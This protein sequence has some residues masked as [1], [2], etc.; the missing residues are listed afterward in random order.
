[1][2]RRDSMRSR[3]SSDRCWSSNSRRR[4][5]NCNNSSDRCWNNNSDKRLSSNGGK[6]SSSSDKRW[7][8]SS[9][10]CN[11]NNNSNALPLLRQ[12]WL[13]RGERE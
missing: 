3:N 6:S 9:R 4:W 12:R 10:C 1:M 5:H 2:R 7:S 13:R 11:C 8:N